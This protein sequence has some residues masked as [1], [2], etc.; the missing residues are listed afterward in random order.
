[1]KTKFLA[2]VIMMAAVGVVACTKSKECEILSFKVNNQA[3]TPTSDGFTWN[4]PKSDED[5]WATEP[6]WSI[7]PSIE[8]SRGAKISPK[9]NVPQNFVSGNVI[10]TVTAEDGV[11]KKTYTVRATKTPTL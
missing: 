4:Y 11:T 1:M 8:L 7:A 10:Y 3:Y 9:A 5:T 2:V 6:S